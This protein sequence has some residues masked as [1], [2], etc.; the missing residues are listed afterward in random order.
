MATI[1]IEVD[2]NELWSEVFGASVE[3]LGWWLIEFGA[4]SGWD[5]AGMVAVTLTDP[6]TGV[7]EG[8]ELLTVGDVAEAVSKAHEQGYRINWTDMDAYDAD[9]VLQ[10][11]LLGKVVFG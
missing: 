9:T 4:G 7:V 2:D 5:R 1:S 3:S 11:A 10:I 6:D 8:R